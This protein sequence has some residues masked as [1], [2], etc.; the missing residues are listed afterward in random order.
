MFLDGTHIWTDYW[1]PGEHFLSIVAD[2]RLRWFLK[3]DEKTW[4]VAVADADGD[5]KPEVFLWMRMS[6][7]YPELL[8]VVH[9]SGT[10][11]LPTGHRWYDVE[12]L[13][14]PCFVTR[15]HHIHTL[16]GTA[17]ED[18]GVLAREATILR[19]ERGRFVRDG[20]VYLPFR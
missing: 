18:A 3:L 17:V 13:P 20:A 15:S 11:T 14:G 4:D 2:G 16:G 10:A 12:I 8:R 9:A 1:L 7:S 6:G 19:W 5:G